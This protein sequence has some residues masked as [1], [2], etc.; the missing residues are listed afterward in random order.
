MVKHLRHFAA[1]VATNILVIVLSSYV[2][3][4]AQTINDKTASEP[5]STATSLA[6]A[7]DSP[8]NLQHR[9][10]QSLQSRVDVLLARYLSEKDFF[11]E[12]D[13]ELADKSAPQVG[14]MDGQMIANFVNHMSAPIILALCKK[15]S[16]KIMISDRVPLKFREII[17]QM[18]NQNLGFKEN[19]SHKIEFVALPFAA[20]NLRN[21]ALNSSSDQQLSSSA[22]ENL[23]DFTSNY[24]QIASFT[25]LGITVLIG[26]SLILLALT[27]ISRSIGD[28]GHSLSNAIAGLSGSQTGSGGPSHQLEGPLERQALAPPLLSDGD[29]AQKI[30]HLRTELAALLSDHSIPTLANYINS[31]VLMENGVEKSAATFELL[32]PNVATKVRVNLNQIVIQKVHHFMNC[33]T[34]SRPKEELLVIIGEELKTRVL[35]QQLDHLDDQNHHDIQLMVHQLSSKDLLEIADII[36][37]DCLAKLYTQIDHRSVAAIIQS[38]KLDQQ[39]DEHKFINA[40]QLMPK[41][42]DNEQL[43]QELLNQIQ[44][45]L[46][47]K[48]STEDIQSYLEFYKD[49]IEHVDADVQNAVLSEVSQFEG[50][51]DFFRENFITI[52]TFFMLAKEFRDEIIEKTRNNQLAAIVLVIDKNLANQ[53]IESLNP[54]RV[55][56]IKEEISRLQMEGRRKYTAA[57]QQAV[58]GIINYIKSLKGDQPLAMLIDSSLNS[59][60]NDQSSDDAEIVEFSKPDTAA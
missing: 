54:R 37:Q 44:T 34:Y 5:E 24:Q 32:E 47:R 39:I 51:N 46:N 52:E 41:V 13:V 55:E 9:V 56:F 2:Q 31:S 18:I 43:G 20:N 12:V 19:S 58:N 53:L 49:V 28:F 48:E 17:T 25:I 29:H 33:G 26:L 45:Y 6:K 60:T 59:S 7:P 1:A 36:D 10:T 14:Y 4:S 57:G 42:K 15:I 23:G 11:V 21:S 40:L 16:I 30:R 35:G 8:S 22:G 38:A 27:K 3:V 50:A